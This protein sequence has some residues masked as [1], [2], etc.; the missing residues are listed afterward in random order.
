M[1]AYHLEKAKSKRDLPAWLFTES[2]RGLVKPGNGIDEDRDEWGRVYENNVDITRRSGDRDDGEGRRRRGLRDVYDAAATTRSRDTE[3]PD[4]TNTKSPR[5]D[6][7]V[8]GTSYGGDDLSRSSS[9]AANRLKAIR[10]AKR[11]A[12]GVGREREDDDIRSEHR[13]EE[14]ASATGRVDT[15]VR[16]GLPDRRERGGDSVSDTRSTQGQGP[17]VRR[18]VGLPSGPSR[19]RAQGGVGT[20]IGGG[21]GVGGRGRIRI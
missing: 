11:L 19:V 8:G 4:R 17:A 21:S 2:E 12:M 18:G 20:N 5:R 1:K 13:E 16:P 10:D 15:R 14:R 9:K 6:N 3:R 7:E